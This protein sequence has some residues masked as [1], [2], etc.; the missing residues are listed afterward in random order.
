MKLHVFD[1]DGTIFRSPVPHPSLGES[2][3][4]WIQGA[5]VEGLGIG[6]FQ[7]PDTLT[8]AAGVPESPA[9]NSTEDFVMSTIESARKAKQDGDHV[10]VMTG[11][12]EYFLPRINHLLKC[13]EFPND[14]V[15]AKRDV[16]LGTV[17]YKA[18]EI[19]KIIRQLN[20]K[21]YPNNNNNSAQQQ[22]FTVSPTAAAAA[23]GGFTVSSAHHHQQY[24]NHN[25]QN[26]QF[27]YD[28]V[29]T[30]VLY[31]DR[32]E[33]MT[34]IASKLRETWPDLEIQ[35]N[36]VRATDRYVPT[37]E[38]ENKLLWKIFRESK[39]RLGAIR[40]IPHFN[41]SVIAAGA[42]SNCIVTKTTTVVKTPA[43]AT[44][45]ASGSPLPPPPSYTES[46]TTT[47]NGSSVSR[48]GSTNSF[49]PA[50]AVSS[51]I[52][53]PPP[54]SAQQQQQQQSPTAAAAT[55]QMS[56]GALG[57]F[58][59]SS[60]QN[61]SPTL[62]GVSAA[63]MTNISPSSNNNNLS[64]L[65]NSVA[66]QQ[67]Q[68]LLQQQQQVHQQQQQPATEV[69]TTEIVEIK[70]IDPKQVLLKSLERHPH[71]RSEMKRLM[72]AELK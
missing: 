44:A 47:T 25:Q 38:M 22:M 37:A 70:A 40:E 29:T 60:T 13:G 16:F 50:A 59:I 12:S 43:T 64:N 71:L 46:T 24:H 33:Q 48:Q 17:K 19:S 69:T 5:T 39:D 56:S 67:Q 58:T 54:H 9:K 10:I 2:W 7:E 61:I 57:G 8:E 68:Q 27:R 49:T 72:E 53:L 20:R 30:I 63:S 62:N 28:P 52:L 26:H 45:N 42:I 35:E 65:L 15:F 11:R 66:A 21:Q 14:G 32:L 6:W 1:F 34:K 4:E 18:Y 3:L 36:H 23:A 41:N 51:S 31:D 55:T